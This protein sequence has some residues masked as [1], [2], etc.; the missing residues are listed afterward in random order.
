MPYAGWRPADY[1]VL[2]SVLGFAGWCVYLWVTF[3]DPLAFVVAESAP[4]WYQGVGPRTW[5]KSSSSGHCCRAARRCDLLA[6]Q[7]IL[8]LCAVLLLPPGVATVRV[9]LPGVTRS[10]S[11]AIPL[12][13]T[14]DFM[15]TGRYVLAA[16]P[17]IAAAGDFLAS[18]RH[19][20]GLRPVVL[21][22]CAVGSWFVLTFS[23]AGRY[24]IS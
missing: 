15:G 1:G 11:S 19:T 24:E 3:G 13:G 7:A 5:F 14:K 4:G 12:I 9:G 17:V 10:S 16:F 23:T 6:V 20:V 21:A 22:L 8:C 18:V 2:I